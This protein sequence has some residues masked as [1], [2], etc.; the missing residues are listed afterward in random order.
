M[1]KNVHITRMLVSWPT[2]V[3]ML[4]CNVGGWRGVLKNVHITRML[5]SWPTSVP[6]LSCNVSGGV[7]GCVKE[8]SHHQDAGQLANLCPNAVLQREWVC[9]GWGGVLKNVHFTRMLVSWPTSVPM[10][11]CNVSGCVCGGGNIKECSHH[12]DAGQLANLCLNAVQQHES[13][14]V[15]GWG[16]G[17]ALNNVHMV[18]SPGC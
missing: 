4:S 17:A 2:S 3:P 5:V 12:Q 6:M 8:C 15:W 7:G 11:S 14:C 16:G 10:L 18:T 9:G 1:L 13:V